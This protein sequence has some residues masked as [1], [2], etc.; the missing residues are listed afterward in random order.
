MYT[1]DASVWVNGFDRREA[2]HASSRQV[3]DLLR[4][5]RLP[6]AVPNLVLA[7]VAGAISRTRGDPTRAEA[8]AASLSRLPNLSLVALDGALAQL[9]QGL[10]AEHGLRGAD[11]VCAAVARRASSTLITLDSEHLT[12]LD[13][14]VTTRTP[15]AL[16]SDLEP[17]PQRGEGPQTEGQEEKGP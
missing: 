4:A 1:V 13:G 5:R 12:R 3:L 9:A 11:A 14:I 17:A 7:E 8:F 2:G 16:L 15:E 10:A 6:V